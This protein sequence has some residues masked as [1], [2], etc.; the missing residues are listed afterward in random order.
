M[1]GL[2]PEVMLDVGGLRELEKEALRVELSPAV[3]RHPSV[4]WAR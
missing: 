2:R 3:L 4:G 1:L